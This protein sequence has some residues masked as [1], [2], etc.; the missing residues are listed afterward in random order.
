M[1]QVHGGR[2]TGQGQGMGDADFFCECTF[3]S[4]HHGAQRSD[5]IAVKGL[6]NPFQFIAAHVGGGKGR[7]VY[8]L[9]IH[10]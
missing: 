2:A 8:S 10:D 1:G 3:K 9:K 4:I 7:D 5:V 6:F